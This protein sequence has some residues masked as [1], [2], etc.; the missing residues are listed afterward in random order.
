MPYRGGGSGKVD[1]IFLHFETFLMVF[2]IPYLVVLSLL[3]PK[4]EEKKN[5][6][7]IQENYSK[8]SHKMSK[9]G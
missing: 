1:K 2:L 8:I 5:W 6:K 7:Y 9:C 4:T 3:L